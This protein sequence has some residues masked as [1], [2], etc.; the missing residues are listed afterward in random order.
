MANSGE[1]AFDSIEALAMGIFRK[2]VLLG[3]VDSLIDGWLGLV[4][5]VRISEDERSNTLALELTDLLI[6]SGCWA[7][8][9]VKFIQSTRS[10][11]Q[12]MSNPRDAGLLSR[13]EQV[14]GKEEKLAK[15]ILHLPASSRDRLVRVVEEELFMRP[16]DGIVTEV[17]RLFDTD[18]LVAELHRLARRVNLVDRLRAAW[19][20]HVKGAGE[21]IIRDPTKDDEAIEGLLALKAHF[22]RI[23]VVGF[24]GDVIFSHALREAFET[25]MNG[26]Q[27][28]PAELLARYLDG[29]LKGSSLPQKSPSLPSVIPSKKP[30]EEEEEDVE[31]SPAASRFDSL[32]DRIMELF[33]LIQGKDVFEAFYKKDL[34]KRLLL[35]RSISEEAE[36]ALLSRMRAECG[37][38]F[39]SRMEGMWRDVEVSRQLWQ[40][41]REKA[42]MPFQFTPTVITSGI[43]PYPPPM[44]GLQLPPAVLRAQQNY[45]N[46]YQDRHKGR[47]L[48]WHQGLGHCIIKAHF[49]SGPKELQVA[50]PQALVLILFA[51]PS[52]S[53][54][55]AEA[56]GQATGLDPV[57]LGKTLGSLTQGR[58]KILLASEED[59]GYAFNPAF[60][61]RHYKLKLTFGSP[62][63]SASD[64]AMTVGQVFADRQHQVD[65]AIVRVM[66]GSRRL[67]LRELVTAVVEEISRSSSITFAMVLSGE[68][69]KGRV[70]AM[71][72]REYLRVD[73]EDQEFYLYMS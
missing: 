51:P 14:L 70:R 12:Q 24:G 47:Q 22:D 4:N 6:R 10:F 43:W 71:C 34:A 7:N 66:K 65:A 16:F 46:Y 41:Y 55:T 58:Q 48:G 67:H 8:A 21:A 61:S 72:E 68:D 49:D 73:P 13:I 42:S 54:L 53:W 40:G 52:V 63:D 25:V 64:H 20:G 44:E 2:K 38:G 59:T 27:N 1:D 19:V 30:L 60:T 31:M 37:A 28:R 23:V 17:P 56:I 57:T 69:V 45:T 62:S 26:R 50:I 32:F 18:S 39:T 15:D 9:E 3:H 29:L 33:R 35:G 5:A 11:L 36:L